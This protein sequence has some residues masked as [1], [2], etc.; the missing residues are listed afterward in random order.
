MRRAIFCFFLI[1]S[2]V[3]V[4]RG[5]DAAASDTF[6]EAA[7]ISAGQSVA[8]PP[9]LAAIQAQSDAFVAAFNQHDAAAVAA[10]WTK[11]AEFIDASGTAHVGQ[12][13]IKQVYTEYFAEHPD[14]EIQMV[15]DS[16][17]QLGNG[18]A[19]EDGRA[20][21]SPAPSGA[22]GVSNYTAVH[23]K[24]DGQWRMASVRDTWVEATTTRESTGDLEFLIGDWVAEEHGVQMHSVCRWVADGHFVARTYTN[25]DIDGSETSGLQLIG[26]NPVEQRMQSWTFSPNG[27]HAIGVWTVTP[28]GWAA[29]TFGC[30]GEGTMTTSRNQLSRLDD[31]AYVWQ[32]T[33][34]TVGGTALPDTDE[35]VIKRVPTKE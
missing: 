8:I 24:I 33:Q 9:E 26:W 4:V 29:E 19:I 16:L 10:L 31:N 20:V 17:R 12:D 23:A 34:R 21:V 15:I 32:S 35:V 30:T 7:E 27:G 1:A 2:S 13:A 6:P 14:A 18:V 5:Q 3:P 11:D 28:T 25:T 22:A